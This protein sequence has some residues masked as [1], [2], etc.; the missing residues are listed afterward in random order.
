MTRILALALTAIFLAGLVP[1]TAQ[2]Y[3][4]VPCVVVAE[5]APEMIAKKHGEAPTFIGG[6]AASE[7][8]FQIRLYFNPETGTFSLF[9]VN[10]K[11]GLCVIMVGEGAEI[12]YVAPGSGS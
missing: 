5:K 1:A 2:Q 8:V 11:G 7:G 6:H 9:M 12:A 10:P 4:Q 3:A